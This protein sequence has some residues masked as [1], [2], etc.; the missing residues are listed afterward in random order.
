MTSPRT[1]FGGAAT[2]YELFANSAFLI[3]DDFQ[4]MRSMLSG[5]VR[6]CG[7]GAKMIDTAANGTEAIT[8][9]GRR[10]YDVVLCDFNL[11]SGKNGQQVLEEARVMNLI[12]PACCWLMVTAEKSTETFMGTAEIQPDAYLIKPITEAV[13][14]ARL[15]KI[16][17]RKQAF[18]DIDAAMAAKDFLKAIRL[19]DERARTDRANAVDLLRVKCQLLVQAG[20]LDKAKQA[21]ESILASRDI[22]WAQ[23]GLARTHHQAGDLERARDI[24]EQLVDRN[25]SY[26]EA[27]DWLSRTYRALGDK[28][29]AESVLARALALSPN[30]HTR[31]QA[32]GEVALELGKLDAAEKAF[33]KS[34]TLSEHSALKKPDP[35]LGLARTA[36]A[37]ADPAEALKVLEQMQGT[38]DNEEVRLRAKA[39][40]GMVHQ[41]NGDPVAAR[42]VAQELS[43]MLERAAVHLD[44]T[45]TR[46]VAG[47]MFATG[48]N[49]KAIA[50]LEAEVMNNPDD[51]ALLDS[52]QQIFNN[53]GLDSQGAAVIEKTR[54]EALTL[55]NQG[56]LLA[57]EERF[58]EAIAA[59][60]HAREK[61]PKNVRVL[62]NSAYVIITHMQRGHF[63]QT[64]AREARKC[65][66]EANQLAPAEP[67]FAQLLAALEALSKD[68]RH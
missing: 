41:Q 19:C 20:Q 32:L 66:L 38:F 47:L 59:M 44:S 56:V 60:R 10:R 50:L 6:A 2:D 31:Q 1:P 39:V 15:H 53:A 45:S 51:R 30:S 49:D 5:L 8:M 42:K 33:R 67:R 34:V 57:R 52:V 7:A 13:L 43:G 17:A 3:V 68:A 37:K 27:Y 58:D 12:G 62:L 29:K 22:P 65:L 36:S 24:L 40:E 23:L 35:F 46:E 14:T 26:L 9:L 11:G 4:G 61:M 63:D 64:L 48:E 28:D 25:R 18:V 55:M 21:Y 54:G 16:K